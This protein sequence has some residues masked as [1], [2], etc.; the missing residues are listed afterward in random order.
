[1]NR[2]PALLEAIA[3]WMLPSAYREHV[4]GDLSERYQ[5][6]SKYILDALSTIPR[7]IISQ[8]RRTWDGALIAI[9]ACAVFMAFESTWRF[10]G[11]PLA[12][13]SGQLAS[14]AFS[15]AAGLIGLILH[16]VY[17]NGRR[18]PHSISVSAGIICFTS[19]VAGQVLALGIAPRLM[20]PWTVIFHGGPLAAAIVTLVNSCLWTARPRTSPAQ[21]HLDAH[22]FY[23]VLWWRHIG[24]WAMGLAALIPFIDIVGH[25]HGT[26][27]RIWASLIVIISLY[28]TYRI[29]EPS[30]GLLSRQLKA[31]Q[32]SWRYL[33]LIFALIAFGVLTD[34][35]PDVA[36]LEP[37]S[38]GIA[39]VSLAFLWIE[40][41]MQLRAGTT[42][43]QIEREA[44]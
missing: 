40:R 30:I 9:E 14:L 25:A 12:D 27:P 6:P 42:S 17:T 2:P 15:V 38:T 19:V 31:L 41:V 43:D 34:P 1:M 36:R 33:W 16:G 26:L 44:K 39:M 35:V 4:L 13:D 37:R 11:L 3:A 23:R 20:L 32:T 8:V 10:A 22:R 29:N 28:V 7:L 18:R 5:S 21:V 24:R